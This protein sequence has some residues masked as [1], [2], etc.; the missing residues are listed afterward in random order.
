M[1][2]KLDRFMT[3]CNL[4]GLLVYAVIG[5]VVFLAVDHTYAV[6]KSGT[7]PMVIP[8]WQYYDDSDAYPGGKLYIYEVGTTTAKANFDESGNTNTQP[9]ILDSDGKADV[10]VDGQFRARLRDEDDILIFDIDNLDSI[11]QIATDQAASYFT[12]N[13]T[14]VGQ[15]LYFPDSSVADQ[16]VDGNNN[17]VKDLIDQI[18]S[19]E[20]TLYFPNDSGDDTTSYTF[21]TATTIPSNITL[22]FENGAILTG[23]VSLVL[24][25][26]GIHA[27]L[28]QIFDSNLALS[29]TP[30]IT[31]F[32]VQWTGAIKDDGLDD[33]AAVQTAMDLDVPLYRPYGEY[34][35]SGITG[36]LIDNVLDLS[37]PGLFVR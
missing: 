31:R 25:N 14:Y 36:L 32:P 4:Y 34:T 17:S 23:S 35:F 5:V 7:A 29:G 12:T 2:E 1:I 26:C 20:A 18:G 3:D 13:I 16:G 24:D 22:E 8:K 9:V 30:R 27:P 11:H 37:R 21:L 28:S 33:T 6:P 10:W 15:N 19:E